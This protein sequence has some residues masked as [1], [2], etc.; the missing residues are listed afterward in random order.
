MAERA[1][2]DGTSIGVEADA[3]PESEM[4]TIQFS[5]RVKEVADEL[6]KNILSK[7]PLERVSRCVA[8]AE[9]WFLS[10]DLKKGKPGGEK[11]VSSEGTPFLCAFS[12]NA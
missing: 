9:D 11:D 6:L 7:W 8:E 10:G 4:P 3:V 2:Q 12:Q 1:E 5:P